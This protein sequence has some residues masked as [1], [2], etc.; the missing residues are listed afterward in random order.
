LAAADAPSGD[1][2]T[3]EAAVQG[4]KSETVVTPEMPVVPK[5]PE[6]PKFPPIPETK[7]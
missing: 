4:A 7:E 1:V 3:V 5:M 2:P 6:T